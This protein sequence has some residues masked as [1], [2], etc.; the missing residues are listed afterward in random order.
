MPPLMGII[1]QT[2]TTHTNGGCLEKYFFI[3]TSS[4]PLPSED[5]C[6]LITNETMS[7][8]I[9]TLGQLSIYQNALND[10][11]QHMTHVGYKGKQ[12]FQ[13]AIISVHHDIILNSLLRYGLHI[14]HNNALFF[15]TFLPVLLA[16]IYAIA[17]GTQSFSIVLLYLL[18]VAT[19][20][21]TPTK[22]Q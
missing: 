9:T 5:K 4:T 3:I 1:R 15:L 20:S 22:P 18:R 2:E 10:F 17:M 19:R 21:L 12:S 16:I 7:A 13:H 14:P 11:N 6:L 8:Q